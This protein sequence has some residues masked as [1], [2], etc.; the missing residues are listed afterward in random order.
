MLS[1]ELQVQPDSPP[2]FIW[3][4]WEDRAVKVE[5]SLIFAA[6]LRRQQVRM[7][8]HVYESGRHGI[9]LGKRGSVLHPWTQD[10]LFWL[11]QRKFTR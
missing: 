6:A 10:L 1:N 2:C 8:L 3:H 5:N 7:A 4:T 11:R 9:G